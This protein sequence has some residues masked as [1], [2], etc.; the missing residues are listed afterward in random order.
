MTQPAGP[1]PQAVLAVTRS[2]FG[3]VGERA[4]SL[5][6]LKNKHG[7]TAKLMT[8]GAT[9]TELDVP[10][11]TGQFADVVLG[12]DRVD[13]YVKSSPYFG[14]SF[15]RSVSSSPVVRRCVPVSAVRST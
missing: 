6:T 15:R 2:D 1:T 5:Y 3:K 12:F 13:E 9:L 7:L 14:A 8:Y 10:D 11:R 4:I